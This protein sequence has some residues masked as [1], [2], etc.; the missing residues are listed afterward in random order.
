VTQRAGGDVRLLADID[1]FIDR[2]CSRAFEREWYDDMD[3]PAKGDEA[4]V[5]EMDDLFARAADAFLGGDLALAKDAYGLLLDAFDLEVDTFCGPSSPSDMVRTDVPEAFARYL[6]AVY[7][8]TP[9]SERAEEHYD[10]RAK[11]SRTQPQPM[12]P[13][14]AEERVGLGVAAWPAGSLRSRGEAGVV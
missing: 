6:R 2:V 1:A 10:H 7:E 3:D 9:R 4:R 5:G 13:N 14:P 12:T 8:T 11:A